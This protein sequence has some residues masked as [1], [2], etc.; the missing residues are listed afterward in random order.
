M[1]PQFDGIKPTKVIMH[2]ACNATL[3]LMRSERID[4]L[5]YLLGR[6]DAYLMMAE[7]FGILNADE[8]K[9]LREQLDAVPA[10]RVARGID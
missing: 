2:E 9:V 6:F 5:A 3:S 10:E 1:I 8:L 7:T 4:Q